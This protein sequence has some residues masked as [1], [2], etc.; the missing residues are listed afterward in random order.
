MVETS[1]D[2]SQRVG[3]FQRGSVPDEDGFS[4]APALREKV[5]P[6]TGELLPFHGS[7]VVH[8]LDAGTR[9]LLSAVADDLHA[10]CGDGLAAPLPPGSFHVTLH[11]LR[12]AP[13]LEDVSDAVAQ[14]D[15][16]VSELVAEARALGPVQMRCTTVFNL[17]STSVVVGLLPATEADC[18]RLLAARALFDEVVPSGPFTPHVTLAYYRPSA[19]APLDPR[20]LARTLDR[21]T[22]QVAGWPV[23][24][25]PERLRSTRF[26]SMATYR[27]AG[28]P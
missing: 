27:D 24:L 21:L 9:D 18:A 1:A 15:P 22:E 16:R 2:M 19:P 7:T 26:T 8:V 11:D 3:S 12:A 4:I 23:T 20:H 6:V 25:A 17:M 28:T 14:D 13:R 10:A 5:A